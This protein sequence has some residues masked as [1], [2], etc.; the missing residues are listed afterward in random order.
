MIP[1][2]VVCGLIIASP[3]ELKVI[4]VKVW[5]N[6]FTKY[7]CMINRAFQDILV[8][9]FVAS[10]KVLGSAYSWP[11][12]GDNPTTLPHRRA[13]EPKGVQPV[14]YYSSPDL[15]PTSPAL[16]TSS[17]RSFILNDTTQSATSV[18]IIPIKV[19]DPSSLALPFQRHHPLDWQRYISQLSNGTRFIL[20]V[21]AYRPVNSLAHLTRH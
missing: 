8:S 4:N 11:A 1:S 15:L 20:L 10:K 19:P 18:T 16:P 6:L 12:G 3:C 2:L 5:S 17:S 21:I 14:P 7:E 9:L 13:L